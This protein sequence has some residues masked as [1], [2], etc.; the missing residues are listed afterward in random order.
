MNQKN[1]VIG[2]VGL[3]YVGLPL[4]LAFGRTKIVTYGF[5]INKKRISDL[6]K[7]LD[8]TGESSR[9][10]IKNSQVKYTNNPQDIKKCSFIVVAVPTPVTYDNEPDFKPLAQASELV[11]THLKKGSII[12]YESTVY[13]GATEEICIPILE[14]YSGLTY[15]KDFKIGYSPERIN[16]G[17]KKN[18]LQ[19][20]I[21]IVSGSDK[22]STQKIAKM[23]RL[24][25]KAG[26]HIAPNIKVAEA[27][28]VIENT[29]RDIN[30]AFMNELSLIFHKMDIDTKAVL[31]AA[32]TKWN[33]LGFEPG[34]VGGH[35]IGV[36]PYY[37]IKKAKS[38]GFDPNVMLSARTINDG[39]ASFVAGLAKEGLKKINKRTKGSNILILGLTFKENVKDIRNSKIAQTI[40][41]L[42]SQGANVVGYDPMI[43]MEDIS[44]EFGIKSLKRLE[45]SFDAVIIATPHK[46]FQ[47]MAPAL[48]RILTNPGVIVDV[49]NRFSK[50]KNNPNIVYQSL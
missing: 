10:E 4:A 49:K 15:L 39:M 26:V 45:G 5:D 9:Q 42:K 2:V 28:K 48:V 7:N 22:P 47:K 32:N 18:T 43:E 31:D 25:C 35:C 40:S 19:T 23:Y 21:K 8:R 46:I 50:L 29:Q 13:P 11:G 16:P 34:L 27:T 37:L 44:R 6:K 38:L 12:V 17:D 14:K 24:I 30:I 36:D 3:G 41:S 33:A 1:N 20:I